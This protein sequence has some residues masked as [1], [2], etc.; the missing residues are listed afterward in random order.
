MT[1]IERMH[2]QRPLKLRRQR[3]G[4]AAPKQLLAHPLD[5]RSCH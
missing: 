1:R 2:E 4:A 5:P 3:L